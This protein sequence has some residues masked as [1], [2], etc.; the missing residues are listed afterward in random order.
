MST[1]YQILTSTNS[2]Y[3]GVNKN[4]HNHSTAKPNHFHPIHKKNKLEY[5][6]PTPVEHFSSLSIIN[7]SKKFF[8]STSRGFNSSKYKHFFCYNNAVKAKHI[9]RINLSTA[10]LHFQ[11]I[12]LPFPKQ[13]TEHAFHQRQKPLPDLKMVKLVSKLYTINIINQSTAKPE[14]YACIQSTFNV[15]SLYQILK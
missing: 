10:H 15:K 9:N 6:K 1:A 14:N 3:N 11:S 2:C 13:I 4:T 8:Q 5:C 12:F 7:Y